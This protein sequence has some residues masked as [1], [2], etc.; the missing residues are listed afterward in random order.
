V[1]HVFLELE[2]A[3]ELVL[4][5]EV[6]GTGGDGGGLLEGVMPVV[7]AR[8]MQVVV[9]KLLVL[10]VAQLLL[11]VQTLL[12]VPQLW[13]DVVFVVVTGWEPPSTVGSR[14]P[15]GLFVLLRVLCMRWMLLSASGVLRMT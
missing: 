15:Q 1:L 12:S 4:G 3:V 14:Q 8:V 5:G 7:E 10:Q 2:E 11:R 13:L 6:G 9:E